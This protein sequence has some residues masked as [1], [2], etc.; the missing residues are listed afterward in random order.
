MNHSRALRFASFACLF[1]AAACAAPVSSSES[2]G[3]SDEALTPAPPAPTGC[4]VHITDSCYVAV[5][6]ECAPPGNDTRPG[7]ILVLEREAVAP[8]FG[9][10]SHGSDLTD[11]RPLTGMLDTY[12]VCT[13]RGSLR[14]CTGDISIWVPAAICG[15]GATSPVDTGNGD[16]LNPT[17][18][19]KPLQPCRD[20]SAPTH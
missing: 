5:N 3:D 11:H 16:D 14:T 20:L 13:Q 19:R 2:M 12:R 17:C 1:A 7:D 4:T 9:D 10:V 6:A 15:G 8:N 18:G